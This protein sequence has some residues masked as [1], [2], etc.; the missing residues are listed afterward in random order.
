MAGTDGPG[1][2]ERTAASGRDP[3]SVPACQVVARQGVAAPKPGGKRAEEVGDAV[4][5][6]FDERTA[7]RQDREPV[8]GLDEDPTQLEH[9]PGAVEGHGDVAIGA[10]D[11]TVELHEDVA[12]RLHP[13]EERGPGM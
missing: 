10:D 8:A 5:V 13:L 1:V 4:G 3:G 6:V 9:T 7:T 11:T 12:H 2:D